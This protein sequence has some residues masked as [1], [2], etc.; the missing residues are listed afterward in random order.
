[1][2]TGGADADVFV[3]QLN[4][5][6]L[7]AD[8]TLAD[9]DRIGLT[10]GLAFESLSISQVTIGGIPTVQISTLTAGSTTVLARI[11]NGDLAELTNPTTFVTMPDSIL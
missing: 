10:G 5:T 7:I 11:P 3:L 9:G 2:L 6:S 8:F 1:M 4:G